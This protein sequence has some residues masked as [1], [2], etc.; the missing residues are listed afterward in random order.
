VDGLTWQ[1]Y[2]VD[3]ERNLTDLHSRVQRSC[4]SACISRYPSKDVGWRR[5]SGATLPIMPCLPTD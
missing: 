3:L 4:A 1:T 5:S 2:E